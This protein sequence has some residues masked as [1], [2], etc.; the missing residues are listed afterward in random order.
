MAL[1]ISRVIEIWAP[2]PSGGT[3]GTGYRVT[4]RLVLT[5]RHVVEGVVGGV[6]D[7][8]PLG[9]EE[10]RD[11]GAKVRW[12]GRHSDAAVLELQGD[13]SSVPPTHF[14]R[15]VGR[16]RVSAEAIGFPWAQARPVAAHEAER[17]TEHLEGGLDRLTGG[18]R[19]ALTLHIEGSVPEPREAGHSP[20]EGLS[21]AALFSGELL[22]GILV[23]DPPHFG[24]DRLEAVSLATILGEPGF[25]SLLEEDRG[26]IDVLVVEAQGVLQPPY[27]DFP[28]DVDVATL[29][30]GA[31]ALLLQPEYGVVPFR[32]R[33]ALAE[34]E[35]WCEEGSA[36][37]VA[38]PSWDLAVEV[39][40]VWPRN[41]VEER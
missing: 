17:D 33:G 16:R 21:G 7:V 2:G 20:W 37:A 24:T 26:A 25:R 22:V 3:V 27:L 23:V 8:R 1:Q 10:W 4:G 18:K 14:G 13:G 38:A 9:T 36:L 41:F 32:G 5:A 19:G 34:L 11:A 12:T 30:A 29:R 28:T 39:R 6:C 40:H 31:T 35:A 15:L